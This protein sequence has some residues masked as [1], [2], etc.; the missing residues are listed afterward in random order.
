MS[1]DLVQK[2]KCPFHINAKRSDII[3]KLLDIDFYQPL[4]NG[5]DMEKHHLIKWYDTL[6]YKELV[7]ILNDE[8]YGI[9]WCEK[10]GGSKWQNKNGQ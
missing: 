3:H 5:V 10:E 4:A 2:V 8:K 1:G 9:C 7:E 6:T